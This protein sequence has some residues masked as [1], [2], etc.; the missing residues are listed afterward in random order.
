MTDN[1]I[2]LIVGVSIPIILVLMVVW[3]TRS[4]RG[5]VPKQVSKRRLAQMWIVD[6]PND[7]WVKVVPRHP[8][9]R[10]VQFYDGEQDGS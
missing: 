4:E 1:L 2:A 10:H 7:G 3:G 9:R 8:H 6:D 5:H